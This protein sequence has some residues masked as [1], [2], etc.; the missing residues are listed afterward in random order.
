ME[1]LKDKLLSRKFWIAC[2]AALASIGAA[3][4]GLA[5]ANE[6][7]AAFGTI[8]LIVT[9]AIYSFCEAY[10]D[11]ASV[12]AKTI[13]VTASTSNAATVQALTGTA[14]EQANG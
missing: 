11:G 13:N 3:V 6:D 2:A 14:K 1:N 9:Q 12:K 10:V 8:C 4:T 5:T 7:L